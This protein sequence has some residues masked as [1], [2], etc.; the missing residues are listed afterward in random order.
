MRFDRGARPL[1]FGE[2]LFDVFPDGEALGGAPFNV[3]W[4]L[5]A[6]GCAPLF[7]SRVGDDAR[8]RSI[9]AA[10]ADWGM[11]TNGLQLDHETPTGVVQV[12]L[13]DGEPTYEIVPDQA[14]DRIAAAELPSPGLRPLLY[15]GSLALRGPT[16]RAALEALCRNHHPAIFVDV[17]LRDP[18]WEAAALR[19][20]LAAATWVK[21]N[22]AE[23]AELAPAGGDGP[24]RAAALQQDFTLATLYVTEGA[25]GAFARES[26]G[27]LKRVAPT[28]EVTVVDAVGAGD[29]FASVLIL[30][31]IADWPLAL[32]LERA[33]SFASA[34]VGR[35]GATI[36]DRAFYAPFLKAWGL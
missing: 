25:A 11:D 23:L 35:R 1:I 17:N 2:V 28:G 6:F 9:A 32:T 34:I 12:R 13:R 24:E 18:W 21:I 22:A 29:A 20:R 10:M 5:Q 33:Q 36:R 16:S 7:I 27:D 3:A 19:E 15:H 31:L 4:H 30:G 14:Y 8:G 26:A